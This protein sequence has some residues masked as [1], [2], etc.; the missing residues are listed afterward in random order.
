MNQIQIGKFIAE[1]RK[2]NN[3]TQQELADKLNV[4]DRAVSKWENGR[5]V[6]D[7]SLLQA[8]SKVFD[9]SLN[10]LLAGEILN[11][12]Y[13][14]KSEENLINTLKEK[15]KTQRVNR[16]LI[17]LILFIIFDL[18]LIIG[19]IVGKRS[20]D[21]TRFV[22]TTPGDLNVYLNLTGEI[23]D[24]L[25]NITE[26]DN[27]WYPAGQKV[28]MG[29]GDKLKDF[30]IEDNE[31][32]ENVQ[33]LTNYI[34]GCYYNEININMSGNEFDELQNKVNYIDRKNIKLYELNEIN[35]YI[36]E[37]KCI[38]NIV[39]VRN[40]IDNNASDDN[41]RL[42][43]YLEKFDA[44]M[45]SDLYRKKH[46]TF[47]EVINYDLNM[48]LLVYDLSVELGTIHY[49]EVENQSHYIIYDDEL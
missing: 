23:V 39:A 13:L 19:I 6:P 21:K 16:L 32:E 40:K 9:V 43:D 4:T 27:V 38:K 49:A 20:Y 47:E 29:F 11:K 45:Q 7:I 1:L 36:N 15:N 37:S 31:Y 3:M 44:F 41:I 28:I 33:L 35:N 26:G 12:K 48:L 22:N 18:L 17:F 5:G 2:Q 24:N 10:E 8:L 30:D 25:Y 46:K 14:E 42:K 34:Y